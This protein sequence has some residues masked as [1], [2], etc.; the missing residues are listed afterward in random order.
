VTTAPAAPPAQAGPSEAA[1][2][3]PTAPDRA[4]R[5]DLD[6]TGMTCA[7]CVRHV[8]LA[9][10][11]VPGV[12]AATV[13]LATEKAG[14]VLDAGLDSAALLEAVR[15]AGYGAALPRPHRSAAEEAAERRAQRLATLRARRLQLGVAALLS[16]AVLGLA[17]GAP[18]ARWSR[19][20]Q[21]ALTLPIFAWVGAIFHGSALRAARHGTATMDTLVSLG[22]TVAFAYSVAAVAFLPGRMTFFDV[23]ALVVTLIAAGKYLE[24]SARGRAGEA[25]EALAGM[26]PHTAHLLRRAGAPADAVAI[27]PWDVAV[28]ELREG[29]VVLVRPGERLPADGVVVEGRSAVDEAMVSGEPTPVEKAEGDE[30][31]GGT[32]NG[33]APLQ[34]RLTRTGEATVLAAI[35]R[36]VER[37]QT[38][39]APVQR[40]ADRVS[41][42]FVPAILVVALL[43]FFGWLLTGHGPV[44]AMVP[45]VAVL[46]VACPCALGLATPAA[47]MVASGRGAELGLL[48]RGGEALERIQGLRAVVLDKT[49]TLTTG[50]P[51]VIEA[52]PLGGADAAQALR[53]AAAVEQASEHPL[54]RAVVEAARGPLPAA[55]GVRSEP[56]AGI[57]GTVEGRRVQV[58][59]PAWLG[60]D[61]QP[62]DDAAHTHVGVAIDGA[63][64]LLLSI[65]DP[66]RPD[67]R[68]GVAQLHRLGLRVVLASGD[69]E[70]TAQSVARTT[71]IDEVHAQLSPAAKAELVASLRRQ[72]GTVA[73]VGDGVNDAPALAAA[74]VG[75][76]VG[77]GS[78]AAMA[79]ADITLVHGDVAAVA[80]AIALS[81]ATLR[82]IRQ[83]LAWAFGYNLV[84]VPLAM[85]DVIPPILAALAMA[86][87][88]VTVVL[89]AL[90]LRRFGRH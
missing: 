8:E 79:A 45:A 60:I 66:L 30:V 28:A 37:A 73:M 21:L 23:S 7:S 4:R 74:D 41:G 84:L 49:G 67:A 78:G 32:V 69:R 13:N 76:A 63:P 68:G 39:K 16:A 61:A 83:N 44:E 70:A 82:V 54:A 85:I 51:T 77:S 72:V 75:I 27:E 64:A 11:R 40:L 1:A 19:I 33:G 35:I 42:V 6:I 59:S 48:V 86:L 56:G 55:T 29:D 3:S 62:A 10:T 38:E 9:L 57:T 88:S 87:S 50:H 5:L 46:V 22:A 18:D 25:I 20:A 47:V 43:T 90:R 89:N 26:Q 24:L 17:Y 36:L 81:R 2:P 31:V 15:A 14:V 80:G 53:L 12:A 71:G 52:H 65:A 34:V 58:G